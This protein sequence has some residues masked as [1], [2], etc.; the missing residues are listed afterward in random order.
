MQKL[1]NVD[2]DAEDL[3]MYCMEY[4]SHHALEEVAYLM[5]HEDY[6][7][8]HEIELVFWKYK[9][10]FDL[11]DNVVYETYRFGRGKLKALEALPME[12]IIKALQENLPHYHINTGVAVGRSWRFDCLKQETYWTNTHLRLFTYGR[13]TEIEHEYQIANFSCHNMSEE[14]INI[15]LECMENFQCKLHIREEQHFNV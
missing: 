1:T 3:Q 14:D 11:D 8:E 13:E 10:N 4:W 15:V 9:P 2:W 12:E 6:P 5:F 7:P